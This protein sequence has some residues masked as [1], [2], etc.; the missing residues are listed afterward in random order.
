MLR[1]FA[2]SQPELQSHSPVVFVTHAARQRYAAYWLSAFVPALRLTNGYADCTCRWFGICLS[3]LQSLH[4]CLPPGH[5]CIVRFVYPVPLGHAV[6]ELLFRIVE[7]PCVF[8]VG[9][10]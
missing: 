8:A 4:C 9:G 5:E 1:S 10:F 6:V 2:R 3:R 7:P